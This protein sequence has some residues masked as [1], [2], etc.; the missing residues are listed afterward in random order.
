MTMSDRSERPPQLAVLPH[1]FWM[2]AYDPKRTFNTK[3]SNQNQSSVRI[4]G[5]A[6]SL[7]ESCLEN[8]NLPKLPLLIIGSLVPSVG[9]KTISKSIQIWTV[10][11]WRQYQ[12][13][14]SVERWRQCPN[15]DLRCGT[16][17]P[18]ARRHFCS[19]NTRDHGA[20]KRNSEYPDRLRKCY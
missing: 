9:T 13:R 16:S 8:G 11:R 4:R 14:I 7:S 5:Q 6:S 15:A 18:Q 20:Q 1:C 10:E 17:E 19:G 3:E 12:F 2:S